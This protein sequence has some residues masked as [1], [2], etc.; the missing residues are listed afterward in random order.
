LDEEVLAFTD[1]LDDYVIISGY[2]AILTGRSRGT[3][4]VD[5]LIPE[6]FEEA[7][8]A[9]CERLDDYW[10]LNAET[11][12]YGLISDDI[13]LR[14][15]R[16]GE[17]LPNFEVKFARDEAERY[18]LENTVSVRTNQ[19]GL[20]ISPLALQIAYKI[21]LGSNKDIED[22]TYLITVFKDDLD[23]AALQR[24][25]DAFEVDTSGLR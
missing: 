10:C 7:Y 22:A 25:G 23:E 16:D 11:G 12:L 18:A 13:P 20:N 6:L 3:E 9:F 4:G 24:W 2:V 19:G 1:V 17:V 15:A 14:F 8:E 21:W 5:V